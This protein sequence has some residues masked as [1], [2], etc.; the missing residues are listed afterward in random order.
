MSMLPEVYR[1]RDYIYG[2]NQLELDVC[3]GEC[4]FRSALPCDE[5]IFHLC[6]ILAEELDLNVPEDA[7][8]AVDLYLVLRRNIRRELDLP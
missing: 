3:R 7:M 5:D 1:T 6:G 2:V 8:G 4:E